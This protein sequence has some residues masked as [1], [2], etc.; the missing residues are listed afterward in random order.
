V[1]VCVYLSVWV[2]VFV[3]V[4]LSV[5][6]CVCARVYVCVCVFLSVCVCVCVCLSV[7]VCVCASICLC[8]YLSVCV[9][10]YRPFVC[11]C[12]CV[13]LSFCLSVCRYALQNQKILKRNYGKIISNISANRGPVRLRPAPNIGGGVVARVSGWGR[14][15][16]GKYNFLII[17]YFNLK[18]CT[19]Q[20]DCFK[21]E[22]TH[23]LQKICG[24]SD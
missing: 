5:C 13:C 9:C 7:C 2:C 14:T 24:H 10:L 6:V 21:G 22:G 12:V 1:C 18:N 4:Y 8:V 11:V 20:I 16:D 17:L 3:Y 19:Y 15:S 23:G